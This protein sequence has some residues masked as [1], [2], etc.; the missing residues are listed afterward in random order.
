[1]S[2]SEDLV[3]A[4][5]PTKRH[6]VL[7][8]PNQLARLPIPDAGPIERNIEGLQGDVTAVFLSIKHGARPLAMDL[9]ITVRLL[10]T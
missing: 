2:D 1:M 5:R 8:L 4:G 3:T 6:R 10:L 9:R 7:G